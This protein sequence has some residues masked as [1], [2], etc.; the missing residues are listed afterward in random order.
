MERFRLNLWMLYIIRQ[1]NEALAYLLAVTCSNVENGR[2][3]CMFLYK[4]LWILKIRY[5]TVESYTMEYDTTTIGR[6]LVLILIL[7][8]MHNIAPWSETHGA[9][10]FNYL[11]KNN[12]T[13][14]V[15]K[16]S[17]WIIMECLAYSASISSPKTDGLM[18]EIRLTSIC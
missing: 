12:E 8:K 14:Y 5:T 13:R 18:N 11:E 1:D 3:L 10:M 15:R 4:F 9:F 6:D 2:L 7:L 17:G 16:K